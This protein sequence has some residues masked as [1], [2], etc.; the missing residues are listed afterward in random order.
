MII[1]KSIIHIIAVIGLILLFCSQMDWFT[2]KDKAEFLKEIKQ[3]MEVNLETKGAVKFLNE[4]FY[5]LTMTT[6]GRKVPIDK[7][8]YVGTIIK[9]GDGQKEVLSGVI[10]VRNIHG[11]TSP[12]LSSLHEVERWAKTTPFWD[13]LAWSLVAITILIEIGITIFE[14]IKET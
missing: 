8:I 13:W 9:R 14:K 4:Y 11:E 1:F 6:E 10:K 3:N 5:T 12:A 2:D 7:I